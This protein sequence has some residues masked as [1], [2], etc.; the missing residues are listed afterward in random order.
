MLCTSE[1]GQITVKH[2]IST[3]RVKI[4]HL[5]DLGELLT[6]IAPALPGVTPEVGLTRHYPLAEDFAHVVGYVGPVSDYDLSKL[7][8]PDPLLQIPKFQIG[9]TGV[10]AKLEDDLRGKA[11]QR[12]IEVN[13]MGREMREIDRR[14]GEPGVTLQLTVDYRLQNFVHERLKGESA[15]AVVMDV[16]NGDILAIASDPSFDPNVFVRGRR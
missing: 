16:T 14:E 15:A 10:E 7:E 9:K 13:A 11:G 4:T 8:H 1:T 12:R 3:C 2:P 5:R 6:G